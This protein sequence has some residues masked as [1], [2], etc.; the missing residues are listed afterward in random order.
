MMT[1]TKI[2]FMTI[3][4]PENLSLYLI[5]QKKNIFSPGP[6]LIFSVDEVSRLFDA[7]RLE[8]LRCCEGGERV[9]AVQTPVRGKCLLLSQRRLQAL[10]PH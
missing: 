1:K 6:R 3:I 2:I 10:P 7:R 9:P 4:Y 5:K 8:V